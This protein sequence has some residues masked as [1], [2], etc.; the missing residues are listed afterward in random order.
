MC[1]PAA[2]TQSLGLFSFC[3]DKSEIASNVRPGCDSPCGISEV[4]MSGFL[5]RKVKGHAFAIKAAEILRIIYPI[6]SSKKIHNF[7]DMH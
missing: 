2:F 7:A 6:R 4:T 1:R 3:S 5:S